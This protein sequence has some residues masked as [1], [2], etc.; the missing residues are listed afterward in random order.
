MCGT[1][2]LWWD[3]LSETS[4]HRCDKRMEY[5]LQPKRSDAVGRTTETV[6][7]WVCDVRDY[8]QRFGKAID[9]D[10]KIGVTLALV[11]LSGQNHCHWNLHI[12]KS[13]AQ[14]RTMLCDYCRAQADVTSSEM[15]RWTFRCSANV[16]MRGAKAT[17]MKPVAM[18]DR[19]TKARA[20]SART[21]RKAKAIQAW[22]KS[23]TTA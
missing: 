13:Y 10:V 6:K 20:A 11:P 9:E 3:E 19:M 21:A 18:S 5:L 8:E 22:A 17:G 2:G 4:S 1:R 16:S 23:K 7:R 12:L 14:V 15:H